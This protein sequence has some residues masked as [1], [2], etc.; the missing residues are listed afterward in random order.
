[1]SHIRIHSLEIY[2]PELS[3]DNSFYIDHFDRRGND[4]R[5]LMKH[6]GRERRY[7]IDNEEENTLTMGIAAAEKV[8][9]RA[10]MTGA[11]MDMIVFSTQ[12]PETT[13]PANALMLHHAVGAPSHA[14]LLDSNANCAGMT[15]AVDHA[16][17][18]MLTSPSVKRALVVG[19]D[20]NTLI[21]NPEDAITFANYGDAAA[22]VILEQT[23]EE[24]GFVDSIYFTDTVNRDKILY[25]PQGLASAVKGTSTSHVI[26]WLPFDGSVALPHTYEM[27][28]T[29]LTRHAL[30]VHDIK[31]YCFSQ[32]VLPNLQHFQEHFAV[33]PDRMIYV[34]D[35]FGY[36]GTSSPF[37]ALHDALE[38][39]RV[40]RGDYVLFW[41]VGAGYQL[42]AMLF[43][44]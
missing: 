29:L 22:A 12:V 44:Y 34:G 43:K 3:V 15:V 6:M 5:R 37:I 26:Q 36:T 4:I 9:A 1:M 41:T 13:F 31:A 42:I 25:P 32:L 14:M 8:L 39:G 7:I 18:Y 35:R 24:T 33:D 17:R 28:E 16:A 23:E 27:V 30:T 2:H 21:A 19:S 11:D 20:Y 40:Q 38:S 10:G